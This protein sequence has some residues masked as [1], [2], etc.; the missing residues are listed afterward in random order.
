MFKVVPS[1]LTHAE[2]ITQEQADEDL[3]A[4]PWSPEVSGQV[5]KFSKP[6]YSPAA[7]SKANKAS[8][9][10]ERLCPSCS[11]ELDN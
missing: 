7:I 4:E 10:T 8:C 3:T 9:K 1:Y 5:I 6:N 11:I 2:K